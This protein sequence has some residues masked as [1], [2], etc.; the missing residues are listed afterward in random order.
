MTFGPDEAA[1]ARITS[2]DEYKKH[3]DYLR[4][5]GYDELDTARVYIG[6]EQEAF[7]KK[8]GW[9]EKGFK[10]ATKWY[11]NAKEGHQPEV[12]EE[13]LATS[14]KELG[15]DCVDIYYLHAGEDDRREGHWPNN[16]MLIV[17]TYTADRNRPFAPTLEA[18]NK[19]HKEGKFKTF[20]ISNFT[21]AEVR[22][23]VMPED[24]T[25]DMLTTD[26][27]GRRGCPDL[28]VQRLGPPNFVPGS[29]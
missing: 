18:I 9:K 2:I 23:D 10:I 8:A 14:L 26:R 11:P 28:Q 20:A 12:I 19:L 1:G 22:G 25:H 27:I 21:A 3:L 5:R 17:C 16:H 4:S 13:K 6:G 7:T 15:T 29:K 24:Q